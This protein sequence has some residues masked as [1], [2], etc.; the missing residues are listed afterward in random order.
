MRA[1]ELRNKLV[2]DAF[3]KGLLIL[4]AGRNTIRFCPSLTVTQDEAAVAVDVF[5]ELLA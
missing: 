1:P 2:L 5:A 4:G 3:A